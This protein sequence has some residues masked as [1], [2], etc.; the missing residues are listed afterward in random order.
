MTAINK[1]LTIDIL[2]VCYTY[3]PPEEQDAFLHIIMDLTTILAAQLVA[4][5]TIRGSN[6]G[7]LL[8]ANHL[9]MD[10]TAAALRAFRSKE[11]T[12]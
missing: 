12:S 8:E 5:A 2:N 9:L 1:Q 7:K 6:I 11:P 10:D 3:H 4:L